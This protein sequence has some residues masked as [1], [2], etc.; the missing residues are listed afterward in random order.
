[1][2]SKAIEWIGEDYI[3][4]EDNGET[5]VT[6]QLCKIMADNS[7]GTQFLIGR[8]IGTSPPK[9]HSSSH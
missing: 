8:K 4:L 7:V 9:R 6:R 3:R 5:I 1:M 2:F